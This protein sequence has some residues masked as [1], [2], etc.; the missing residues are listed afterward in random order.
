MGCEMEDGENN[1]YSVYIRVANGN[2]FF[3]LLFFLKI[4]KGGRGR[5]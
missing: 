5:G 2:L 4:L 3:F 1:D